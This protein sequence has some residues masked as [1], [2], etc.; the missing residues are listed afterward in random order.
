MFQVSFGHME[1]SIKKEKSLFFI[2]GWGPTALGQMDWWCLSFCNVVKML[3]IFQK[4][5]GEYKSRKCLKI[6]FLFT[7]FTNNI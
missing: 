4:H 6:E 2:G 1:M 5:F 7:N 3:N